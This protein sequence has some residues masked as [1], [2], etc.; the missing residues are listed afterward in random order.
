MN[1]PVW[2]VAFGAG[3]LMALV[4]IL[5]VFVSHFAV[6]GGLFLVITERRA[7]RR[8]DRPL[9]E[10]LKYHSRFFVLVTVVF[11]AVSGVGIWFTISLINPSATSSLIHSYVWG[12]A[13]E[14]VFFFVE[15]TAALL[16][17]H[18]WNRMD[19]RLH[20]WYGWI[21]FIA[22]FASMVIIN[23]I[24]TFMLTSGEWIKTHEFWS[25]FFNPTFWPSLL[26]RFF[27]S[28]ALAGIYALVTASVQ[29]DPELKFRLVK[30]SAVWIIP[31]FLVLPLLALWYVRSVPAELWA[32]AL[33]PMPT[34]THA[35]SMIGSLALITFVLSLLSLIKP[36]RLHV[37][38]SL[39]IL[40]SALVTMG[41]FEFAREAVRKPYIIANYM[42]GNSLYV[43]PSPGDGGFTAENI[44]QAG[45]LKTAKWIDRSGLD[46]GNPSATGREIFRVECQSC[47]TVDAYRGLKQ[48]LRLRQWDSG[49]IREM[50]GGIDLMHNGVMP[51][52]AG[53]D[54]ERDALTAF[55]AGIHSSESSDAEALQGR[56]VF[57]RYCAPC[58]QIKPQEPVFIRL[59][60]M[61]P[62]AADAAL[63]NLT[64]IFVRMPDLQLKPQDRAALI[65]WA[66]QEFSTGQ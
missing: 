59:R 11:G 8:N 26:F 63:Q 43:T 36:R 54:P 23:G 22:A 29:R 21:Y 7:D 4:S 40:V 61:D 28:L 1:Y 19:R 17:M 56:E 30:W 52:F 31:P 55:L 47:H 42:Y 60:S 2:D 27:I 15:I 45:I 3:L 53:K 41:A 32:S 34:A 13:I 6:G 48:Y 33:G 58:H 46:T 37:A 64:G 66:R 14:W 50:L 39:L 38:L 62:N 57:V 10:W 25:G 65:Q 44:D 18:G 5:H 20:L 24:V 16:Y 49:T 9:M 35:V 12:W 51:P